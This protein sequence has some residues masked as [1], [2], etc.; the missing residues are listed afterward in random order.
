MINELIQ[1]GGA[2]I[3]QPDKLLNDFC[4]ASE[5]FQAAVIG[6]LL[7]CKFNEE[8]ADVSKAVRLRLK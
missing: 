4:Q 1:P 5:N 8:I 3:R 7:L 6:S 2:R